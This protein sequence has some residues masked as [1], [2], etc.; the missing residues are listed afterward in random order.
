MPHTDRLVTVTE[1]DGTPVYALAAQDGSCASAV[2][3]RRAT[4]LQREGVA[5]DTRDYT[6]GDFRTYFPRDWR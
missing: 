1:E 5:F 3:I 6:P 4:E 2:T